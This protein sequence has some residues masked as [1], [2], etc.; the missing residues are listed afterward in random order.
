MLSQEELELVRQALKTL[1]VDRCKAID[2]MKALVGKG[3]PAYKSLTD[4]YYQ[5]IR[6]AEDL[7]DK[8]RAA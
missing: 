8:L 1:R 3:D 6:R 2:S 7:L 4:E 5:E